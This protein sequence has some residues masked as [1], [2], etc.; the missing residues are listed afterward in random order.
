M[1]FD[2][3]EVRA[4]TNINRIGKNLLKYVLCLA[5]VGCFSETLPEQMARRAAA[6]CE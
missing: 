4:I 5:K 1:L 6:C 2:H 3:L